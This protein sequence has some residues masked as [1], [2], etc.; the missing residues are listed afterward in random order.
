VSCFWGLEYRWDVDA[1]DGLPEY[2]QAWYKVLLNVYDA[3]GNEVATKGRSY[4]FTYAKEAVSIMDK[5]CMQ[6]TQFLNRYPNI[7][8]YM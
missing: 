2:M 8:V 6:R 1:M 4:R 5:L 3:I 7:L